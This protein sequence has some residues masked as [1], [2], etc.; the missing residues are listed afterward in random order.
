MEALRVKILEN[1]RKK[2]IFY[3]LM[4]FLLGVSPLA[5]GVM[6][7]GC[8]LICAMPK[9]GRREVFFGVATA[10]LFDECIPLALFCA[11]Y[12]YLVL[13]AKEKNGGVYMYTRVLL[14]FSVSALRTAYIALS[15][16]YGMNDVF[17]LLAAV[18]AY[19]AFTY[20][21][22][23]FF[24]KKREL[25]KKRYPQNLSNIFWRAVASIV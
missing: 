12:L 11:F 4:G 9:R 19:P 14:S 21:F 18:I 8:A 5:A 16:V 13:A 10:S 2:R 22:N 17:R 20:A 15:G 6:P 23:G 3:A 24:D 7:F 25:Y 1:D